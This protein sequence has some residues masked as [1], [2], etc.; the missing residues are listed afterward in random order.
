MNHG[1]ESQ[2]K[3]WTHFP[4]QAAGYYTLR[5][6]RDCLPDGRQVRIENFISLCS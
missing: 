6:R 3:P 1:Y 5:L 4:P 2:G